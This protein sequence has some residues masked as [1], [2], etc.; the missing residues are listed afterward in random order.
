MGKSDRKTQKKTPKSSTKETFAREAGADGICSDNEPQ[1]GQS[2]DPNDAEAALQA[3]L[4]R[5]KQVS[6]SCCCDA[7]DSCS[8]QH[9]PHKVSTGRA[10]MLCLSKMRFYSHVL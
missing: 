6:T 2:H 4:K 9:C 10:H 7:S 8:H 5:H 1:A 3:E